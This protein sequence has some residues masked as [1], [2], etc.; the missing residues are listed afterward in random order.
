[1]RA[2][3]NTRDGLQSERWESC[4]AGM[5]AKVEHPFR[6]VKRQFCYAKE[7]Y[8]GLAKNSAQV[9]TL[10]ALSNLL[11]MRRSFAPVQG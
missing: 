11:T 9:L 10:F 7:R 1:M 8:R 2:I 5:R 4:K 3:K 6:V